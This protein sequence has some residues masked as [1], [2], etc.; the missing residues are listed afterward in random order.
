MVTEQ[1]HP[2]MKRM[3][4]LPVPSGETLKAKGGG[5]KQRGAAKGGRAN[6]VSV[7]ALRVVGFDRASELQQVRALVQSA[8]K[9]EMGYGQIC[10]RTFPILAPLAV[11]HSGARN[12][13]IE[14][15]PAESI[16]ST[17]NKL[18]YDGSG[19]W[20]HARD[21]AGALFWRHTRS[22]DVVHG[23]RPPAEYGA[24]EL[25]LRPDAVDASLVAKIDDVGIH[26]DFVAC[27]EIAFDHPSGPQ[28]RI[29][30][31]HAP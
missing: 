10:V 13:K 8:T 23:E 26:C 18:V 22:G 15:L 11:T 5:R 2:G 31:I 30:S 27:W 12:I 7:A 25:S 28:W 24:C 29:H 1:L 6:D 9:K 21:S 17:A 19:R 16:A 4:A 20:Q 14:V 3:L